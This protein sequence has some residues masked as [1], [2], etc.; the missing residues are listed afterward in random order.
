MNKYS[1]AEPA[2]GKIKRQ[3]Q[4]ARDNLIHFH[5]RIK[6]TAFNGKVKEVELVS[7]VIG[8]EAQAKVRHSRRGF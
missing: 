8:N 7:D 5:S 2:I 3:E 1:E 6:A 4:Q